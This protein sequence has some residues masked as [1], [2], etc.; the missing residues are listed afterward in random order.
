MRNS[1][2]TGIKSWWRRINVF[3]RSRGTKRKCFIQ[4]SDEMEFQVVPPI[5]IDEFLE[6]LCSIKEHKCSDNPLDDP[7]LQAVSPITL[8][9][10]LE[11][12]KSPVEIKGCTK[13]EESDAADKSETGVNEYKNHERNKQLVEFREE[14]RHLTII[15]HDK[16][17]PTAEVQLM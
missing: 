11:M 13:L 17:N 6:K 3:K 8:E 14:V 12:L 4:P 16:K 2:N 15:A 1:S 5:S 10:Y 9:E 7:E